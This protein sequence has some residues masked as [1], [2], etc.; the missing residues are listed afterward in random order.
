MKK[1]ILGFCLSISL[2]GSF[3]DGNRLVEDMKEY[4]LWSNGKKDVD[5]GKVMGFMG[6]ISGASDS[7]SDILICYPQNVTLG[8]VN[9]I[10]IKYIE[11]NPDRWNQNASYLVTN[12]LMKIF[13]CK[14]KK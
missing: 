3:T 7:V 4:K 10:V 14:K 13:P 9:A 12:P 2:Y 11:N 6:Y 1:V 5:Y 8:Q